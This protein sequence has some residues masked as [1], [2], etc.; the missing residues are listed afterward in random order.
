MRRAMSRV[1]FAAAVLCATAAVSLAEQTTSSSTQTKTFE[2]LA[3]D[4][5]QLIV[6]LP[7]GTRELTVPNDFRFNVNG[8]QMSV[9]ELKAGMKGSAT[10]TTQTTVTPVS[11]TEV[12][13]GTVVQ[14]TGSS[15]IVRTAEGF[16]SFTQ[17]DIDKRG[18]KI[19]REGKPATVS[20][21]RQGD[22]LSATIITSKPPQV[23]TERQVNAT[24]ATATAG[25]ELELE[26]DLV[27]RLRP[28]PHGLRRRPPARDRRRRRQAHQRLPRQGR[29]RRRPARGRCSRSR[30]SCCS[31]SGSPWRSGASSSSSCCGFQGRARASTRERGPTVREHGLAMQAAASLPRTLSFA[32][33]ISPG[34]T[35]Q[36]RPT[37]AP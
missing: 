18:V 15:I 23:M 3:V 36:P 4:G 35:S 10:I 17:G 31:W 11:V 9:Q 6:K 21:F 16:K 13:N 20:D 34:S 14:S 26:L 32:R 8:Q 5:N 27:A 2:V 30:A 7:E 24:L 29:C 12:K 1:V 22:V 28:P 37:L 33:A 25:A 19:M